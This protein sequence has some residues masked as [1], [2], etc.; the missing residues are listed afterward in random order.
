MQSTFRTLV[1]CS[2]ALVPLWGCGGDG[3]E[4]GPP[5]VTPVPPAGDYASTPFAADY[6]TRLQAFAD[7]HAERCD[8]VDG[9]HGAAAC[10]A[11]TGRPPGNG[12]LASVQRSLDKI[13]SRQDTADFDMSGILRLLYQF[14][15]SGLL[16]GAFQQAAEA[17][18]KGFKYWPDE[19]ADLETAAGEGGAAAAA[20]PIDS[21]CTWTENHFI[22][23]SSNAYL[24]G[25]LYPDAYFPA[26][27]HTGQEKMDLYRPR[28][29][30]WLELRY[31]TGFSEW[32]SNVYYEE[33]LPAVLNLVDFSDD[34][35]IVRKAT[36]V[37]D[38]ILADIALNHF[39]GTFGSTHGRSYERHKKNGADDSTRGVMKL[40]YG[41][42]RLS[43]GSMAAVSL[44]LS[45]RY[46]VPGVL[47]EMAADQ[48][49]AEILNRQRIGIRLEEADRWG[50][51]PTRL[52]DGM[53]FLT[54]EAYTHPRTIE[55]F[56]RMLDAYHWWE[57]SFFEPFQ[58]Y[59]DLLRLVGALGLL[60]ELAT[61]F[62]ADITRNLRT[63]ANLY[64]YRTP[65]YM[66]STAQDYRAG[67]GGDQHHIWQA[68]LGP[69]AVCFTTHP[70][71]WE[72]DGE[73]GG[74][75]PNYWTGSGSL[76]RV[77]QVENVA[78][79]LYDINTDPGLYLTHELIFTHAWLPREKFDEV[80][81]RDG[82]IF[83][84]KG[85]GYLAL[86]SREPCTWQDEGPD[87]GAELVAD[88]E[89]NVW[90]CE[91]GRKAVEGSFDAFVES[92][93]GAEVTTDGLN[94]RYRSPSQ[95]LLELGWTGDVL[96]D[97]QPV[98]LAGYPRYGNPYGDAP[99]P[100]E[101]V[102][103]DHNG[104]WLELD[105]QAQTRNASGYLGDG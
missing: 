71:K 47:F 90:I 9:P 38:L 105:W 24:A 23:F 10:L 17:A 21:M 61:L 85:D 81:E 83:A 77:A 19:L 97:G 78:V 3:A 30:R 102:R 87:A 35:E 80:V 45:P 16:D 92:I 2:L 44:A 68:T 5:A 67:Y 59:E 54:L 65:D 31:R 15:D 43:F 6:N 74:A 42:N 73:P 39:Q 84:R 72:R 14:G 36:M 52:E 1:I 20:H 37:A 26:G 46:R 28:I 56:L 99:F 8:E 12:L 53:T 4:V 51:D 27:D 101:R 40:A 11:F 94:V 41:M 88:G 22:L 32:L 95:G 70:A 18:V 34:E 76:P 82:W 96:Q 64:T 48:E 66:L 60:P 86:W 13:D 55:L 7:Y 57:N 50:L 104:Q 29:L 75:S 103:F 89:T 93:A 79:I 100:G 33:D 63:E 58:P 91:L 98:D 25:Q 69:E 49:R 62:E